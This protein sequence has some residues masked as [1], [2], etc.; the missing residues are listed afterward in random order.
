MARNPFPCGT[1][2]SVRA[3]DQV[4]PSVADDWTTSTVV[5]VLCV[6]LAS[7]VP[8][9]SWMRLRKVPAFSL[10]AILAGAPKLAPPGATER[11]S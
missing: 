8:E 3:G 7:S 6:Q 9:P 5:S 10:P 1:E 2:M 11:T 4:R